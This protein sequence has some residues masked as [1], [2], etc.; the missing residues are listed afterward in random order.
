MMLRWRT[1]NSSLKSYWNPHGIHLTPKF[2]SGNRKNNCHRSKSKHQK[3]PTTRK[4]HRINQQNPTYLRMP[5]RRRIGILIE[6]LE[7]PVDLDGEILGIVVSGV[8]ITTLHKIQPAE[9]VRLQHH[10][11]TI[12]KRIK[13]TRTKSKRNRAIH[14][15][16]QNPNPN[17][18]GLEFPC[19]RNAVI[20]R[21]SVA[22]SDKKSGFDWK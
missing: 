22:A 16:S 10:E 4:P 21:I 20:W 12:Y 11:T 6:D 19:L 1:I 5:R 17:P 14:R 8:E 3:A 9:S 2:N 15:E 13:K 7:E 18:P